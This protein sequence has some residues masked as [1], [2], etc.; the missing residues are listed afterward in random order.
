MVDTFDLFRRLSVGAKFNKKKFHND[1]ENV[2]V[3]LSRTCYQTLR[4][5][6]FCHL[7]TK[8]QLQNIRH[9]THV[10]PGSSYIVLQSSTALNNLNICR[11]DSN[12]CAFHSEN[13]A[14]ALDFFGTLGEAGDSFGRAR[15]AEKSKGSSTDLLDPGN[16]KNKNRKSEEESSEFRGKR[17]KR[18]RA[19]TKG[20]AKQCQF[21]CKTFTVLSFHPY[22]LVFVECCRM[23]VAVDALSY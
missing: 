18:K 9:K 8:R 2:K 23:L 5:E 22:L 17:K 4:L 7:I 16:F 3:S 20:E 15:K 14:Q 6:N 1:V 19:T 11:Q 13:V 10:F 12:E 21:F